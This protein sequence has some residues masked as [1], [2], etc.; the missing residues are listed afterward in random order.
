MGDQT[1]ERDARFP[2]HM[3][4]A[5]AV[6]W[7]IERDPVL[8][9]TITA[10]ALLDRT[11]DWDRLRTR[12]DR[13]SRMIPRLRQRVV[14]PPMRLGLPRWVVDPHFELDYHL[15]RVRTPGG[16]SLADVLAVAEPIAMDAFHRAR[17]LWQFTLLEGL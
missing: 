11:P 5:D 7:D 8:R 6:M 9:S 17:P 1:N 3:A 4:P 14:V 15:R 12:L 16:G 10:V 2:P 13:A